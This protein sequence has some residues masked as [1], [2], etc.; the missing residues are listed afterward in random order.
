MVLEGFKVLFILGMISLLCAFFVRVSKG[1][2]KNK[3]KNI[4]N[5]A[6]TRLRCVVHENCWL[7]AAFPVKFSDRLQ[8]YCK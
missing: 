8:S 3:Q 5:D 4:C 1:K 2:K 7:A 6:H